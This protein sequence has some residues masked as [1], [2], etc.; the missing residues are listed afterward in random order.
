MGCGQDMQDLIIR[1]ASLFGDN[2][3]SYED[4]DS[5]EFVDNSQEIWYLRERAREIVEAME[6]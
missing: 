1:L 5:S 6:N 2:T 4:M 3:E